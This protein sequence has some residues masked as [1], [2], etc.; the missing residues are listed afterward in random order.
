[1]KSTSKNILALP[2]PDV[3][4]YD[5]DQYF[6]DMSETLSMC[7]EPSKSKGIEVIL[8]R[9][10]SCYKKGQRGIVRKFN[11]NEIQ[12]KLYQYNDQIGRVGVMT[13]LPDL[14]RVYDF[15]PIVKHNG[16]KIISVWH[17]HISRFDFN[18]LSTRQIEFD[19][20]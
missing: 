2:M 14:N 4:K 7:S 11:A 20:K 1:M 12:K 6:K 15:F 10:V 18:D 8:T 17:A 3:F 13:D 9:N 5:K 16:K 19:F